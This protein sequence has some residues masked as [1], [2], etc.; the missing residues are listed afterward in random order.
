[1][2]LLI[3]LGKAHDHPLH[4][5][6]T[7]PRQPNWSSQSCSWLPTAFATV[8]SHYRLYKRAMDRFHQ[9]SIQASANECS[10]SAANRH[11]RRTCVR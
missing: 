4:V 5:D 11:S 7:Y 10:Q 1:M 3:A 8:P 9:L 2:S 6:R